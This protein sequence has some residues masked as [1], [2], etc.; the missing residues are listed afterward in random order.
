MFLLKFFN[1]GYYVA[2]QVFFRV[3]GQRIYYLQVAGEIY[4]Q[5]FQQP[6]LNNREWT[7]A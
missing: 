7:K 4:Q 6:Y 1:Q 2:K 5:Y 3:K